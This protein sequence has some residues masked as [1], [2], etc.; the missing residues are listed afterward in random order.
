LTDGRK[1]DEKYA[2]RAGSDSREDYPL[3]IAYV[4][5]LGAKAAK[6]CPSTEMGYRGEGVTGLPVT[7]RRVYGAADRIRTGDVQLGKSIG[8]HQQR[9]DAREMVDL[10]VEVIPDDTR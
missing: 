4:K 7:P 2:C 8:H 5:R 6:R 9:H 3:L 1:Q 10:I